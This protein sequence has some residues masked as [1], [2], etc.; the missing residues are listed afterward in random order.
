MIEI[1]K[2][3]KR[4]I[5]RRKETGV[6]SLVKKKDDHATICFRWIFSKC[7]LQIIKVMTVQ[8]QLK[9]FIQ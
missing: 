4:A 8:I 2:L 5:Q 1:P 3:Q 6:I 9:N 7:K